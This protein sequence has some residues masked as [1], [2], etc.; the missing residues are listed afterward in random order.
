MVEP[1]TSDQLEVLADAL[2][3]PR[4]EWDEIDEFF[5]GRG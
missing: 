2:L 5:I 1:T 4:E 3:A